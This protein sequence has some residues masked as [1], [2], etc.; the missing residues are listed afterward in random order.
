MSKAL[1]LFITLL[2][3]QYIS[4]QNI[5][6][7]VIDS[8]G[9]LSGVSI[10]VKG[11]NIGTQTD[12]DGKY[13]LDKVAP[14]S[15]LI[16]S[17]LGYLSKEVTVNNQTNINVTLEEDV[18]QLSEVVVNIGYA[19]KKKSLVT[20]AI[21]SINEED[22]KGSSNQRVEQVLQ[23]KTSGVTVVSSSGAPGSGA[24]VRIRGLGTNGNADPIYIVDGMKVSSID[25]IA[26]NDI[27]SLEVLKDAASTAIYG[28]Q[29]A[30]GIVMITTKQG[31]VGDPIITYSSQA[32]MQSVRTQMEL[33]NASQFVT[34][35]QEAGQ[36]Q[37]VNNGIN[38]NWIDELFQEAILQRHD[39]SFSGANDKTSYYLSGTFFDQNGVAGR[40]SQYK[41]YTL[42]SNI[43]SDVKK[44]LEIGTNITY[45]VIGST[46]IAEDDSFGGIVNH[47]LL[48][49]P[50]TP[51]IYTGAL[52]QR[53][54]DGLAAGT[55]MTD[56]YGNVYG[57]PTYSTGEVTNPVASANYRFRGQID[58]DKILGSVYAKLKLTK[59]LYFTS[60]YGYER[61]NTFDNRWT[62][63]WFVSSEAGNSSVTL[64]NSLSRDSRW[65]WENFMS[66]NK[67]IGNHNFT[68]L[69][70]YSAES[71]S[72]PSYILRGAG[73]EEQSDQFAYFD[74]TNRD[75]DII[76]GGI[77]QRKANSIFGR[78][79]YDYKGKYLFETSLRE[80]TSSLLSFEN[81]SAVFAAASLG[82]VISKENFWEELGAINYFK[83]RGS[84]GQNGSDSNLNTYIGSLVFQS[85]ARET[86]NTVPVT[87]QGQ[88]GVAAGN[89]ANK[90][91][92][93]ERSEQLN[94][95]LDLRSLNNKLN[96]SV[97]YYIKTTRDLL[98]PNGDIIAPP[99][100]GVGV[101]AINAGT[102]ENKGLE[103]ELGYNS[104]T[105]S[106]FTYGINLNFS[107]LN[108]EVT[109]IK[110]VGDDGF[111]AGATA[112]QNGDGITRFKKGEPIWYFYG[113]Q[114]NGINPATGEINRVDVN[115]DGQI[116]SADK[117]NIGSPH[118]DYLFGGNFEFGYKGF[119]LMLRFQG[120][121]GNDIFAAYHQPTR[122][123]TNKPI[124]FFDGRWTQPGD[125]ATYPAAQFASTAYD[126]DLM[127]Q[128]GSY[129]RIKQIQFGYNFSKELSNKFKLS[130]FRA[131]ISLDDYFTFTKYNGLDPESGS[132][133]DNSIGVDRGFYPIPAKILLGLS[134]TF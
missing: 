45:S 69:L 110:F 112:P 90:D 22:I 42:R 2:S 60:R 61:R 78:L 16:F 38:T 21:S 102:V 19:V 109:E 8:K 89:L 117:T 49:D 103:L 23:G 62:P 76:G 75:N 131:Y 14:G 111:I 70:G 33:M 121:Y 122:P 17:Y 132:F 40:A 97:D 91:L 77:Y 87:Y 82:W 54:I 130:Q 96:F 81:K 127:V 107:T 104:S 11:T 88:T 101:P 134:V 28:T 43:K 93:W 113:Y 92:V 85:V 120:T 37:V 47:A 66:Y 4:G 100:L 44:W 3:I 30:N 36:T 29:G 94:F 125:I 95:G 7:K 67:E 24:K 9:S 20:G 71:I 41:R 133:S 84:W 73:V 108:N 50:L 18:S 46:P 114:T 119:D 53:A 56:Q 68:A 26:P 32:G 25:N 105:D 15:V 52:P 116:T 72:A 51:V 128:D 63:R 99:S 48:L 129:M 34:Y 126:T 35:M 10:L 124:E 12:F 6:G 55:A 118:P 106:G 74:F 31:K 98:L 39:I 123:I 86:G 5:S 64:N 58:T 57:Y 80:D 27:A 83:L 79:S 65:L 115:G 13:Q 59:G 1:I